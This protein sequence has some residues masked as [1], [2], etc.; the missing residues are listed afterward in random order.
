[1]PHRS[2]AV[3]TGASHS[4]SVCASTA[5]TVIR[6]QGR[7]LIRHPRI[8][9]SGVE[10]RHSFRRAGRAV[11][12][13]TDEVAGRRAGILT[14]AGSHDTPKGSKLYCYLA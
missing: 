12:F 10:V 13:L 8:L 11:F 2:A 1:M 5:V 4:A 14:V 7:C 9:V 6:R 3:C